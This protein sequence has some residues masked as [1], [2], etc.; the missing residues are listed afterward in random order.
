MVEWTLMR[1]FK[2]LLSP[3]M[4]VVNWCLYFLSIQYHKEF[5]QSI[6]NSYTPHCYIALLHVHHTKSVSEGLFEA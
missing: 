3:S 2:A 1:V 4:V 5:I 6:H